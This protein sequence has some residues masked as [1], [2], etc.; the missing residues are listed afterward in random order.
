MGFEVSGFTP[1]D[2]SQ[3]ALQQQHNPMSTATGFENA[4]SNVGMGLNL[5]APVANAGLQYG[6]FNKG[7]AITSGAIMGF[8]GGGGG[9]STPGMGTAPSAGKFLSWGTGPGTK[10]L[11]LAPGFTPGGGS[12]TSPGTA[13]GFGAGLPGGTQDTSGFDSQID[14]MMNNNMMFLALQT[15]VQYVSQTTQMT[16]N[17][18]KTDSDAKLNAIRNM[19][20]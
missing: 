2:P 6:G 19:R 3:I 5:L 11:D 15:K 14:S 13:P 7:A 9:V 16:S 12:P 8:S 4:M 20:S 1:V 10:N 17:I 18:A